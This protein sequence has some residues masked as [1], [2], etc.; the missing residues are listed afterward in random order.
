LLAEKRFPPTL[1]LPLKG[2]GNGGAPAAPF[3]VETFL[4]P[5]PLEGE[6]RGGGLHMAPTRARQLR[7]NP[8]EAERKL[9]SLLRQKQFDGNRFRRQAP[10]G[11][12]IADFFC[13]AAKLIIELDGG[14][15]AEQSAADQVRTNWLEARGYRVLRF[16]N[17]EIL[18]NPAG[19]LTRLHQAFNETSDDHAE[20][21]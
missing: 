15:H 6:G 4:T 3:S 13:P 12:Y 7:K 1:T 16:W 9:W 21:H 5:S 17:N 8:T 11:P 2:G 19:A 18:T 14:Q 10:I 20:A